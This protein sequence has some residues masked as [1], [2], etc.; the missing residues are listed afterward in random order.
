MRA[1]I[2][3][4]GYVGMALGSE[5]IKAG[6]EVYGLRRNQMHA[7][8]LERTGIHPLV[9]D[10]TRPK[11]LEGLP[12]NYDWVI[13]CI[14]SSG[15]G[16]SDYRAVYLE[17]MRRLLSWL[18]DSPPAR[19]VYT[20]STSVYGQNDGSLVTEKSPTEPEAETS[21]ILLETEMLLLSSTEVSGIVLRLAGIYG[22]D[23]GY[24]FKQF[25]S[26]EATINGNGERI[27]NMVHR[28]DI[29][30]AIV[31]ALQQAKP[32]QIYNVVDDEPVT[33]LECFRWL[34]QR[35]GKPLPPFSN[36]TGTP[37]KRGASNKRVSNER[38]KESLGY[39]FKY[40]T[41]REGFEA[42]IEGR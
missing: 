15:G 32:G 16:V 39:R 40:P 36:E 14:S 38:L 5:L 41:F 22:P 34:A 13:N 10:I 2:L 9:A 33:Q 30:G 18:S 28:D 17:G 6:H 21:R 7:E 11:E 29:A 42:V 8:D 24:W 20:S 35:L 12:Q 25:L 23:R 3:G 31:A 1:L 27:L 19:L 4:C 37:R 26:G